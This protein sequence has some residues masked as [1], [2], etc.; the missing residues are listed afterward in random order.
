MDTVN[1]IVLSL[2]LAFITSLILLFLGNLISYWIFFSKGLLSIFLRVLVNLPLVLP[3]TVMGFYFLTVFSPRSPLGRAFEAIGFPMVFSFQGLVLASV[4]FGLPFMINPIL[5]SLES[6]PTSFI[7]IG[8]VAR[9][10]NGFIFRRL[11]IPH[12]G[13]GILAGFMMSFAHTLGEFGLIL[14]IGGNIPGQTRVASIEIYNRVISMDYSEAH[15]ISAVMVLISAVIL[16]AVFV[17][18]KRNRTRVVW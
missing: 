5:S 3:P 12:L 17:W 6:I 15:Y 13:E 1:P 7:E 8:K 11:L 4:L 9:R 14:M 10:P 16:G 2:G 18:F